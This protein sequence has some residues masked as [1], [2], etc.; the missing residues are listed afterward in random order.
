M[1]VDPPVDVLPFILPP[2]ALAGVIAYAIFF[3]IK[4]RRHPLT[5]NVGVN[6]L[7]YRAWSQRIIMTPPDAILAV[8]TLRNH[9]TAASILATAATVVAFFAF[10]RALADGSSS[11]LEA[12]QFFILGADLMAAFFCF[13]LSVR[14]ASLAGFVSYGPRK[15]EE[16]QHLEDDVE[17]QIPALMIA[18]RSMMINSAPRRIQILQKTTR[19]MVLFWT[20]GLRF[21]YLA[22]A[23]AGWIV[24]PIACICITAALLLLVAVLDRTHSLPDAD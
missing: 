18:H 7:L 8:Q 17:L 3:I 6:L 11:S 20:F 14:E 4:V 19:A 23:I 16:I 5:T 22:V 2:I 10:D 9:I 1:E 15:G 13:A 12:V 24:S 21:Y